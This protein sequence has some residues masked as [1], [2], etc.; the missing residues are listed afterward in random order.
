M[1][2]ANDL[3]AKEQIIKNKDRQIKECEGKLRKFTKNYGN[4]DDFGKN[5]SEFKEKQP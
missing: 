3:S 4:N 2:L 5:P 1:N